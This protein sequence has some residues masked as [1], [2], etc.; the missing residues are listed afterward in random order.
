MGIYSEIRKL[1]G[2]ARLVKG[3][4]RTGPEKISEIKMGIGIGLKRCYR[5]SALPPAAGD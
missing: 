2:A 4:R 1:S 3:G 5:L